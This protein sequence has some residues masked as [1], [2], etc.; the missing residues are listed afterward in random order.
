MQLLFHHDDVVIRQ[1][2]ARRVAERLH[3]CGRQG[4]R[5]AGGAMRCCSSDC[6]TRCWPLHAA[7]NPRGPLTPPK[8]A[9]RIHNRQPLRHAGHQR[10]QRCGV[11]LVLISVPTGRGMCM[12]SNKR[13]RHHGCRAKH[14]ADVRKGSPTAPARRPLTCSRHSAAARRAGR[15]ARGGRESLAALTREGIWTGSRA[16]G[17]WEWHAARMQ[18][19]SRAGTAPQPALAQPT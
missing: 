16:E 10:C 2:P 7:A 9:D 14:A 6:A 13:S 5:Q 17:S 15:S 4:R 3:S 8:Q 12:G 19:G 18:L 1:Q 11:G